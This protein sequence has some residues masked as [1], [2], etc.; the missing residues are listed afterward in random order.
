M[1][2]FRLLLIGINLGLVT[3]F[4]LSTGQLLS[5]DPPHPRPKPASLPLPPS[6]PQREQADL[7]RSL[8]RVIP[9][10]AEAD[11]TPEEDPSTP[12]IRLLGIALTGEQRIAMVEHN[13]TVTRVLEGDDLEG[14]RVRAITARTIQIENAEQH[15]DVTLDAPVT[16]Q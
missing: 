8:F 14:W 13:G 1:R 6:V 5:A 3:A 16:G 4:G 12:N 11:N 9:S 2:P 15:I 7:T 10:A